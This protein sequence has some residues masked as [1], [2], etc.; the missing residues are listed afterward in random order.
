[1]FS[2]RHGDIDCCSNPNMVKSCQFYV[3]TAKIMP[4]IHKIMCN[5]CGCLW[6]LV[7]A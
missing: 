3:M 2:T 1:M 6:V 7:G 5:I 4:P